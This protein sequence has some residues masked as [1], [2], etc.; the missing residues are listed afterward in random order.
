MKL[1][2]NNLSAHLEKTLAPCYLVSGDEPLLVQEALDAIRK[3]ARQNGFATRDLQRATGSGSRAA[4]WEGEP[5]MGGIQ[6][7]ADA[8]AKI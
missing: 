7:L 2:L 8:I 1:P 4:S 6:P 3:S 5:R